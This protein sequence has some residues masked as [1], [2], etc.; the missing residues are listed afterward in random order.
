MENLINEGLKVINSFK[1]GNTFIFVY[2]R[3]IIKTTNNTENF[4]IIFW[5]TLL[6]F[7]MIN[8]NHL[9]ILHPFLHHYI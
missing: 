3:K 8:N 4:N 7:T 9:K 5:K 1:F 6:D 2:R